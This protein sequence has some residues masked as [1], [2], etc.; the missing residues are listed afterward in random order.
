MAENV[1]EQE[2]EKAK[3]LMGLSPSSNKN[4]AAVS[5]RTTKKRI[6]QERAN[7]RESIKAYLSEEDE[8]EFLHGAA[9]EG[10]NDGFMF[11]S[12]PIADLYSNTTV[13]FAD[14]AGF[15][16]WSSGREPCDVFILLETIYFGFD[17]LARRRRV[18]KVETI[19]DCYGTRKQK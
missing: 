11:K 19:G 7:L 10:E 16:S 18:F 3:E 17:Q 9:G 14:I 1:K 13:L 2:L 12:K 15:T 6:F 8:A 5:Y 4:A